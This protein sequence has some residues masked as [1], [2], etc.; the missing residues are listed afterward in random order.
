MFRQKTKKYLASNPQ[1]TQSN[2]ILLIC[3]QTIHKT[4]AQQLLNNS[5]NN[6]LLA[7]NKIPDQTVSGSS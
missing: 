6:Q 3:P 1:A 2:L 4:S 7:R 5:S